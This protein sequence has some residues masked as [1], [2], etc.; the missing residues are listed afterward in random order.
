MRCGVEDGE[1]IGVRV[2][3][4]AETRRQRARGGLLDSRVFGGEE[5]EGELVLFDH[6]RL[7]G[8]EHVSLG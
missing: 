3:G 5:V 1:S 7:M 8:E 4:G 6:R 2:E